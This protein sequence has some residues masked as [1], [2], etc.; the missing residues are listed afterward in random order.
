MVLD[1]VGGIRVDNSKLNILRQ[2]IDLGWALIPLHDVSGGACSCGRDCGKSAGKHPRNS[3]WQRGG[4]VR[5]LG[6][7]QSILTDRPG[8]NWGAVTG[9]PSGIWV[10]D[11]DPAH[12]GFESLGELLAAVGLTED[13]LVTRMHRTGSGGLHIV[14]LIGPD[15]WMPRTTVGRT[16]TLGRGLD[17]RADGGQIVLP[18]SVSAAGE[19]A[20][21]VV[22]PQA[23]PCPPEL[24][25]EIE[26]RLAPPTRE[27]PALPR[28]DVQPGAVLPRGEAYAARVVDE[29]VRELTEA[30][31]GTRN[32]T[33]YRTACRLQELINAAWC[34][35]SEESV[36]GAW[37]AAATITGAPDDEV[38]GVWERARGRVG[39]VAAEL[40][41]STM[42]GDRVPFAG[43]S[44]PVG[45][46]PPAAG[47]APFRESGA[48]GAGPTT[49]PA[50][51]PVQAFLD[52]MLDPDDLEMRPSPSPLVEGLLF[53]DSCAWL[54]GKSGTLKSFIALDLAAHVGRGEPWQGGRV[55]QGEAWYVVGEGLSGMKLRQRA[56]R[57][58]YGEMKSVRFVP[59][60]VQADERRGAGAWSVMVEAAARVHPRLIVL[61]TQARATLGLNENDN[62]DMSY[63]AAQADRLRSASGACVLVVHHMG[64][65]ATGRARGATA[66][67]GAQDTELRVSREPGARL[68]QLHTDKQKD[69]PELPP[70]GLTVEESAESLV[71]AAGDAL[72]RVLAPTSA[73]AV[74]GDIAPFREAQPSQGGGLPIAE[75]RMLAMYRLVLDTYNPGMGGSQARIKQVTGELPEFAT[76]R[77]DSRRR[78]L[79]RTWSRLVERGLLMRANGAERF[80]VVV[81]DDQ[82]EAGA[83]TPNRRADGWMPPDG[84][85]VVWPDDNTE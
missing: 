54:I 15:G 66:I 70:I 21:L 29:L 78:T 84:W 36:W 26:R 39:A 65:G 9:T 69:A 56:W 12:G 82:S 16:H 42:G 6:V 24:R 55:E 41:E 71:V 79:D 1:A 19:Y 31:V 20:V 28:A 83:L 44:T 76:L 48:G 22:R 47:P 38:Y 81:L 34:S 32:D 77:E 64:A 52:A 5:D 27:A 60:P 63:F 40:P 85:Q 51:D 61:D 46:P 75:L 8:W 11:V 62:T 53:L 4:W 2:F 18:G 49:A 35:T 45:P 72:A 73:A 30:E 3:A 23:M 59:L 68:V 50:A 33:A 80:K 58:R 37:Y 17:V 67:D 14:F 10:L 74:G 57:D 13:Q 25:T 43:S 7:L